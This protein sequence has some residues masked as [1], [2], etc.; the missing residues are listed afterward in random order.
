MRYHWFRLPEIEGGSAD[1]LT[2]SPELDAV[3][4]TRW[5]NEPLTRELVITTEGGDEVVA[6]LPAQEGGRCGSPLDSNRADYQNAGQHWYALDQIIQNLNALVVAEASEAKLEILPPDGG[7]SDPAAAPLF[8]I[9]SPVAEVLYYRLG[10]DV[11]RWTPESGPS[12]SCPTRGG[13]TC[14]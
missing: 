11:M 8:P 1:L 3:V 13:S 7:W 6:D 2:V 4:W 9:W 5:Q 14:R 10:N 12:S